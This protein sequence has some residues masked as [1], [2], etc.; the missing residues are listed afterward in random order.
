MK[1]LER[2]LW[3]RDQLGAA[4]SGRLERVQ[5]APDV[6]FPVAGDRLLDERDF[7]PPMV[8]DQVRPLSLTRFLSALLPMRPMRFCS[9]CA[10]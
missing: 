6:G 4:A 3:K 10:R 7:H 8:R 1:R 9:I 5:A 2:E